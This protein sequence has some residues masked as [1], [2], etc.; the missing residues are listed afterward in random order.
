MFNFIHLSRLAEEII[1]WSS[2]GFNFIKL[3][4]KFSTGSSIMP[5]KKK[6]DAAELIRAKSGR[7]LGNY[8]ALFNVMKALPLAY[9]KDMQ[10]DKELF[11]SIE[12]TKT[13]LKVMSGMIDEISFNQDNMLNF[14]NEGHITAT[15][16]ADWLVEN[17]KL[18]FR[19]AHN[20]TEKIVAL[21]DKRNKQI[22]ELTIKDY[23]SIDK[24]INKRNI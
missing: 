13:A 6:S 20:I 5:Q 7:V 19:D 14:C 8:V 10:E 3:P 23:K 18:P 12:T 24:R 22:H 4:E 9:S 16:F 21:A 1:L 2:S 17:I 11:D 15:D